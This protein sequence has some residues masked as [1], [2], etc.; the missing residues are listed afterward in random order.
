MTKRFKRV[1]NRRRIRAR[2]YD[3]SQPGA[4]FITICVADRNP[5]L[6]KV[7]RNR[8]VP[9]LTGRIVEAA[10]HDLPSRFEWLSVD[11]FV[12]MP[13]HIHGILIFNVIGDQIPGDHIHAT[14][15][16]GV[17]KPGVMNHAPT[18]RRYRADGR[19]PVSLGEVVR[20][21]KAAATRSIRRSGLCDF[22]WQ[23]N[24]YE[25]IIRTDRAFGRIREYIE[26][27]PAR[28]VDDRYFVEEPLSNGRDQPQVA[29]SDRCSAYRCCGVCET[30]RD[31]S[32]T[33]GTAHHRSTGWSDSS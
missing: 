26:G 19:A 5:V 30:F 11:S 31:S 10:W 1:A 8:S 21:F 7:V 18:R 24:Y 33:R 4:Y 2:Q 29:P 27:N 25:H 20:T 28:W 32:R 22:S 3:Y 13:N 9:F 12:V 23:R 14:R 17:A 15:R 16:Q 6:G